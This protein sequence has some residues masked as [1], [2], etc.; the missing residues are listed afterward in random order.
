MAQRRRFTDGP[1]YR[2]VFD[3]N[4]DKQPR[5]LM[6]VV[7][8]SSTALSICRAIRGT[9]DRQGIVDDLIHHLKRRLSR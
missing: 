9:T 5:G 4:R 2:R 6:T 1:R 3:M 8:C 7:K